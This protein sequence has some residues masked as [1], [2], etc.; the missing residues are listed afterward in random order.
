MPSWSQKIV[1]RTFPTDFCT[2]NFWGGVSRYATTPLI[3]AL[4]T[5]RSDRT[6]FRPWSPIATGNHLDCSEVIPNLFIRMA[7]LPF[8][9][10]IQALRDPLQGELPNVQIFKNDGPTR[11]R[12]NP[13]C[14]TIDLAEIRRSSKISSWNWSIIFEVVTVLGSPGR[15]ASQ[16]EKLPC[17]WRWHTMVH[18]SL[19]F[20]S[21][22][23]EFPS[24]LCLAGEKNVMTARVSMLLKSR[25]S[26]DM[27]LFCLCNKNRLAIRHM[28]R[29]LFPTT[30][31]V[32]SYDIWK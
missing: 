20:L 4:S 30:L 19:T 5:N 27:L 18:A 10:R 15:G 8:L 2:L 7:P 16:V 17:F 11:S 3:A 13:S 25:A 32:P 9:I 21:E 12:E 23:C 26:P 24:A 29:L 1:A 28:N 6:R 14:S 31:S 22:W